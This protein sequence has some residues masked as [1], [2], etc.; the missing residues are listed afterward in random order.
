MNLISLITFCNFVI[1]F[2]ELYTVNLTVLISAVYNVAY[3]CCCNYFVGS[4]ALA[5]ADPL[6]VDVNVG[7]RALSFS[8]PL[9]SVDVNV[10]LCVCPQL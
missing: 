7:S 9:L 3:R 2:V 6:S 1:N 5:L 8:G 10:C 4:R